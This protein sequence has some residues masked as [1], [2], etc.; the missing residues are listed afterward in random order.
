MVVDQWKHLLEEPKITDLKVGEETTLSFNWPGVTIY[1]IHN[2]EDTLQL[3]KG[4]EF[5]VIPVDNDS[6]TQTDRKFLSARVLR[7]S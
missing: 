5:R 6:R 2:I 4:K 1:N 7:I 3:T